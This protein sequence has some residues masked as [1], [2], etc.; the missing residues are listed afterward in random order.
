MEA[1]QGAVDIGVKQ[2]SGQAPTANAAPQDPYNFPARTGQEVVQ[3]NPQMMDRP[4]DNPV[5]S[6]QQV[7]QGMSADNDMF[8]QLARVADPAGGRGLGQAPP[9][10]AMPQQ[11][12]PMQQTKSGLI[13]PAGMAPQPVQGVQDEGADPGHN[14]DS[15]SWL[16]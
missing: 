11:Q 13:L 12:Q 10:Q 5:P 2:L 1:V 6:P 9:P 3:A 15:V 8:A 14:S 16:L 7:Q 4:A